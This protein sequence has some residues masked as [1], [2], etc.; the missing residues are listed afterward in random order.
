MYKENKLESKNDI[1]SQ[2]GTTKLNKCQNLFTRQREVLWDKLPQP[3]QTISTKEN[4]K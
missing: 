2:K 1:S 4:S 3:V